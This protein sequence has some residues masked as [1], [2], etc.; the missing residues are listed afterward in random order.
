MYDNGLRSASDLLV[1]GYGNELRGDDA[2]GTKIA[3]TVAGWGLAGVKAMAVHQ[4]TPELAEVVSQSRAVI[5]V[6]ATLQTE[7]PEVRVLPIKPANSTPSSV[8]SADPATIL[9]LAQT[10]FGRVPPGWWVLV[11]GECFEFTESLSPLA[12][13]GL[14][15]ALQRIRALI[16]QPDVASKATR[17]PAEHRVR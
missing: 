15:M 7:S 11:P 5:F 6:D 13:R 9:F 10:V 2:V 12:Q 1:I 14:E 4:L 16:Q 17:P 3:A 8:H